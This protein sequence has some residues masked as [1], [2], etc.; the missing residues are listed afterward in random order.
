MKFFLDT[1]DIKE[2]REAAAWGILDGVTTNPSHVAETGRPFKEVVCEILEA[3]SGPVSVE[4]TAVDLDGM[5]AQAR[6]YADWAPNVVVKIPLIIEGLKAVKIL[7]EEG[8][9]TNV[10]LCFSSVQALLAAK[11]GA[12]YISPFVGRLDDIGHEGLESVREI[13]KIYDNYQFLTQILTASAR[14][15]L[16]IRDAALAGSDV[17][18][19]PFETFT[20]LVKHPL[21]DIGL[22]KFLSDWKKVPPEAK[23]SGG[24]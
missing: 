14:S 20:K 13:R 17:A 23:P 5:L 1:A 8:I 2:V 4:V 21:T 3:I 15:P 6:D 18:T 7:S 16:H 9:K 19:M 12:T 22:E 10:T 11:A 24:V